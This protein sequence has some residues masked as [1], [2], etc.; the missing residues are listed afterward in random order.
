MSDI[1]RLVEPLIPA[2]RRYAPALVHDA[3]GAD[4]W[5]RIAWSG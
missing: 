1:L 4:D 3:T 2:L 5:C